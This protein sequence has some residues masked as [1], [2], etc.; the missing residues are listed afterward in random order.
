MSLK[1]TNNAEKIWNFLSGKN[2]TAYGIAGLMGNLYA[3]S[4]LIPTNLQNSY[5]KSLGMTDVEYTAAVDSGSYSNFVRDSAGYGLAQWTYWSRKE[6][7][8]NYA[9]GT[10]TNSLKLDMVSSKWKWISGT[11]SSQSDSS[12]NA[13]FKATKTCPGRLSRSGPAT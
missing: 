2:L 7:L 1:G 5:E 8:L 12:R 4:A 13:A 11:I 6:A 3:E 10:T 9:K